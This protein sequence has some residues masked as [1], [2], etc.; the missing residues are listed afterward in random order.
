MRSGNTL[1]LLALGKKHEAEVYVLN[2]DP[3]KQLHKNLE[4]FCKAMEKAGFK[5]VWAETED[6]HLLEAVKQLGYP[7]KIEKVGGG[8]NGHP[9]YKGTVNV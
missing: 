7:M 2:A 6:T 3:Y 5:K 1:F 8:E 4:E 9:M